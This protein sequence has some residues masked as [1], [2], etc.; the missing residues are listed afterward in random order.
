MCLLQLHKKK[1]LAWLLLW[2]PFVGYTQE[3]DTTSLQLN[4][5][6]TAQIEAIAEALDAQVDFT[7][8]V[9]NYYFYTENKIN[10][11]G[12]DID[13][14]RN[15]Y[16]ITDFQLQNLQ[17]HL[18][19]FGAFVSIY[20]LALVE[21]FD[22]KTVA[23]ITPIID[24]SSDNKKNVLKPKQIAK[25]GR[26]Q[27]ITRL[28]KNL[29]QQA[30]YQPIEDS[31]LWK[32]PSSRYLGSNDK[33]Y[34]KYSFNYRNRV[35]AGIT[36]DKD[37]GE[38]FFKNKVNDS[39]QRI[40][41]SKLKNGFDFVSMHAFV[42]DV[43]IVKA[44]ALGDYHLSF[45]QGITLWSGLSFGKST[46]PTQ[47]MRFGGG[48]KANSSVNESFFLRGAAATINL[49]A[50]EV[51]VFYS[52][53]NI[54]ANAG[55]PDSLSNDSYFVTSLQE[56]GLHRTVNELSDKG[57]V[58]QNL[59]G[60]RVAFRS[61]KLELGY[62]MH[63]MVLGAAL[64]PRIYPYSQF[65]FQKDRLMNQGFDWRW[66]NPKIIFFGEVGRSDNG[67]MA[68]IAGFAAQPAGFVSF[69]VAYRH[70]EKEYQNLFSNA[71]S[72]ST[73]T[74]NESGLY[75]GI[76]A[77]LAPGWK[78]SAYSDQFK[79]Q[80]L[81]FSTDAP[82]KGY[83]YFV[84]SDYRISRRADFY[85]RFRTK[86]KMTNDKSPLN[87]IDYIVPETKNTYRFHI[88]YAVSQ[89]FV[90]KS[91]AELIDYKRSQEPHKYGFIIYQD[92][93]YRPQDQPFEL[94]FRYA[95]F[96]ADSYDA[97]LYAYESDVL[98]AFSIPAFSEKGSRAYLLLKL[99]AIKNLDIWARIAHTWYD[100]R[101]TIGSGLDVIEGNS[102]TDLKL[103]LR[104]KF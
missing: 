44:I 96:D 103:Q 42:A 77:S 5:R 99:K 49:K 11:N 83:D 68:G 63:Q 54:D 78:L 73:A 64:N 65:R 27:L 33:V 48:L 86:Q 59:Y 1:L 2:L 57:T 70:Y 25:Y 52:S 69:T 38:A 71:F 50:F 12:P 20:E 101:S 58:Q 53:K 9:E 97:R 85:L 35:K 104:W 81:R 4:D 98:Y 40:L 22:E 18:K 14:L 87:W 34:A 32:K 21:G 36:M 61:K 13:Q 19:K 91:R 30:G 80:W 47:V 51:T 10:I 41:G 76:V 84:Q 79:F 92:V 3:S 62:T 24:V 100:S 7:D 31:A 89:A 39:L 82:S 94:S 28:E 16:L 55:L 17:Q 102:K 60:G 46:V 74:N 29:N 67:G 93:Q 43:G 15:L 90:F 6:I 56:S 23:V 95:V 8:L 72:E 45:G 37:A 26:H 66:V 88:N 75:A